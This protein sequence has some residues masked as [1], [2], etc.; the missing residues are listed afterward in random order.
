MDWPETRLTYDATIITLDVNG[1]RNDE[2]IVQ[3]GQSLRHPRYQLGY[4]KAFRPLLCA[5][6]ADACARQGLFIPRN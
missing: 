2:A 6:T 5:D 3:V 1:I 4:D